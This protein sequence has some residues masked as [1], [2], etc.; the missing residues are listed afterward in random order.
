MNYY[1]TIL[2]EECHKL[3]MLCWD[4]SIKMRSWWRSLNQFYL[5]GEASIV[6]ILLEKLKLM[7]FWWR[8]PTFACWRH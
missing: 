7:L 2:T 5:S 1:R 3:G 8:T 6:V 4:D